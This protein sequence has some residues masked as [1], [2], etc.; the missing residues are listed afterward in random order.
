MLLIYGENMKK[1]VP[2]FMLNNLG[3]SMT[4]TRFSQHVQKAEHI[5]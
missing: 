2:K 4:K 5:N 1:N 3:N